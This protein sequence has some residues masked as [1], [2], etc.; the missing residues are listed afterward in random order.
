VALLVRAADALDPAAPGRLELLADLAEALRD[1]GAFGRAQ[2]VA[3]EVAADAAAAGDRRLEA[4]ATII[5][6][7]SQLQTDPNVDVDAVGV[8]ATRA[9]AVFETARD[10]A[11]LAKTWE[12]LAWA[13]WRHGQVG[14]VETALKRAIH[15]ARRADDRRTEAQALNLLVGAAL[16]GPMPVSGGIDL[17]TGILA[18]EDEQLRIRATALRALGA[19]RAMEGSFDEARALLAEQRGIL[20]DLGLVVAAAF[21]AETSALVELLAGEYGAAEREARSGYETLE[22]L[23]ETSNS[24]NLAAMVAH[25]LGAQGRHDEALSF[26]AS[27]EQVSAPDDVASQVLWR[28]ARAKALAATGRGGDA[29]V[30]AR[31]SV[32]LAE[33]TDFVL[34]HAD[35]LVDLAEVLYARNASGAAEPLERALRLYVRKGNAVAAERIRALLRAT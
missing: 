2:E 14:A 6:L 27:S 24:S 31:E 9:V 11:R 12:L 7:R 15:H 29:E 32:I 30:L 17:C 18:R 5:R 34:L 13:P 19:F 10:D 26:S 21:A 20:E 33:R 8:E 3:A 1:S 22:R 4:Q 16:Y 35:A 25:A 28:T 23:G